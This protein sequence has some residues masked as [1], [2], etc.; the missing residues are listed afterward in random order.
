MLEKEH[1]AC[2]LSVTQRQY[3]ESKKK[4][5]WWD[6]SSPSLCINRKSGHSSA[7]NFNRTFWYGFCIDNTIFQGILSHPATS[8]W[9]VQFS[10]SKAGQESIKTAL[11]SMLNLTILS[12]Q[13]KK[14]ALSRG[15][16]ELSQGE[17]LVDI[18]SVYQ[19]LLWSMSQ[20]QDVVQITSSLCVSTGSKP[21]LNPDFLHV[22]IAVKASFQISLMSV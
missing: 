18:W 10:E 11:H 20:V 15:R 14:R 8:S 1:L 17:A 13:R 9:L 4:S 7:L 19:P 16:K 5:R 22:G 2:C 6:S 21:L 12:E 3:S